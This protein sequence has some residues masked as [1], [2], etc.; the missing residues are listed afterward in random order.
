MDSDN[1]LRLAE[2]LPQALDFA[3]QLLVLLLHRPLLR[4]PTPGLRGQTG[5][6]ARFLLATPRRQ[7]R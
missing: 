1:Q 3:T 7:Q 6:R 4:L 2:L 5:Q